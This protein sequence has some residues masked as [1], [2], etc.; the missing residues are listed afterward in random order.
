MRE[1]IRIYVWCLS[2][3][4]YDPHRNPPLAGL[5]LSILVNVGT[6]IIVE[7]TGFGYVLLRLIMP[8]RRL[9]EST[10]PKLKRIQLNFNAHTCVRS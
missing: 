8:C 4:D 5:N 7:A 1:W 6:C 3:I 9:V 10:V 2:V